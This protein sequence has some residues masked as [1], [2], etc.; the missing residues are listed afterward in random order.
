[1]RRRLGMFFMVL[2][3]ALVLGALFLFLRNTY[4]DQEAGQLSQDVMPMI[5]DH[6][7]QNLETAPS[8][9]EIA[10]NTPAELLSPEDLKMTEKV[11]NGHAYI[12]YLSIP[13]LKLNLPIM[14]DWSYQKLRTAP[15]RYSGTL[16]G[17][18][19]VLLA[20]SYSSHFGRLSKL[21]EG[22]LVSF[23][24]MD[25]NL[26]Q[27]EVAAM[28]ILTPDAVEEMTAGEYD[29]TLFTCTSNSTHR[30]TVRCSRIE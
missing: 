5:Y 20:H 6:I 1:M 3:A 24:D 30:I 15:C 8:A 28:D 29:L 10:E 7:R 18:D 26:W 2:G 25:G 22:S 11:I 21:S 13:E 4:E 23:T 27:Y 19:L 12:G 14:S 9:P 16:K 17:E